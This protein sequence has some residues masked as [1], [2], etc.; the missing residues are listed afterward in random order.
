MITD[1]NCAEQL[2]RRTQESL[3][4]IHLD[5]GLHEACSL[6]AQRLCANVQPGESRIIMCL[7][8]ALRNPQSPITSNCRSK[9]TERNKLWQI[10]HSEYQMKLPESWSD[11]ASAIA[12]HPQRSSILTWFGVGLLIL[13][14]IGCCC[15]RLSKRTHQELKNR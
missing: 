2:A 5:P 14:L 7:V 3:V 13:L 6:D 1:R 8:D 15:G 12:Q 11:L 10:A 9:L 4:D